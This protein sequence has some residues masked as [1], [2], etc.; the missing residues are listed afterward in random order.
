MKKEIIS[1]KTIRIGRN[2]KVY[3]KTEKSWK[4][5]KTIIPKIEET[6]KLF[7][8]NN[9]FK[10]LIDKKDKRFLKGRISPQGQI[11]GARINI[12]PDGQKLDKAYSLLAKNLT[13]HDES[14][15]SHWDVIY[16][17][18]NGNFAYCYN[19][20]KKK[21]SVKSKYKKVKKFEEIYL[22]LEKNV[23]HALKDKKDIYA[24][25][26]YT[27]L[28]TYMRIGNEMYYKTTG[29][30]GL[31]TLTKKDILLDK[32]EATFD[33]ISKNGVPMTITQEFPKEYIQRMKEE[34]KNKK[35]SDFIFT[36]NHNK[37]LKDTDFMNAFENYCGERFYP[38]IVRSF[39]ATKKAED[40][41]KNH[42]SAKKEEIKELFTEIAEKLGHK[43]FDKKQN[44]WKDNYSVTIHYYIQ[45][46]LV[47]K[48]QRLVK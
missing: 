1:I 48:I 47:D 9:N 15:H 40:F 2:L 37:P 38:H 41:L 27:L 13:F 39:Y 29:H 14:S 17:N 43:K 11:Q 10:E 12:L 44:D 23:E 8:S 25:P 26:M 21:K 45:P 16:Q 46:D 34:I 4:I 22:Q 18:P 30:K 42:K 3:E 24:I 28:K 19:L 5:S 7:K 33:Y 31:T 32:N 6:I 20:E 35:N 36:N